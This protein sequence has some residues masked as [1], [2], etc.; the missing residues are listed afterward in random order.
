MSVLGS[1]FPVMTVLLAFA[2]LH[3]RPTRVQI[4]GISVALA[5]V[6][7]LSIG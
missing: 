4:A 1:L 6:A 5:G 7:A 2:I 3:E